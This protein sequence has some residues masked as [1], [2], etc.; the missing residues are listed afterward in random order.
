MKTWIFRDTGEF[1][2][3]LKGEWFRPWF[4]GIEQ[5]QYD[6]DTKQPILT[7]EVFDHDPLAPIREVYEKWK[8]M[9]MMSSLTVEGELWQA[10]K[11]AVEGVKK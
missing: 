8:D 2:S 6:F 9:T 7:L 11:K 10:I 5:A 4:P 1:R 3:P